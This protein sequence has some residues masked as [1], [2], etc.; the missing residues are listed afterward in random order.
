[1][2]SLE[3]ALTVLGAL[4]VSGALVSGIAHRSF[5]SLTA[6][7]VLVGVL[8]GEGGLEVL[9]FEATGAFVSALAVVALVVIL[10]RDGLEVDAEMLRTEWHLPLRKLILAMPITA[11]IVAVAVAALTDLSWTQAFLVGALLSPTDPVLSS[12]VVTNPRVPRVIRHSLNLESGLNDGLALPPVL[13][14]IAA[15]E[16]SGDDFVWW[17]FVLQDVSLGFAYGVGVGL[18]ASVLL[19]RGGALTES[20]PAH[21]K[22]LY[23]LGV[24]F[25]TYGTTTLPPHG[26][27][28][29]AVFV[30]AITLGIRRPDIRGYF[31]HRAD[32]IIEIVKLGIFV[33]FGALLTLDGLF[34]DGWAAVAVAAVTLLVARPAAVAIALAGTRVGRAAFAFMAWF[35]PKGVAT[36]TFSLLVLASGVPDAERI[37]NLGALVVLCSIVLHGLTDTPGSEWMARRAA[38][39]AQDG[40]ASAY[41]SGGVKGATQRASTSATP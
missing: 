14:L 7:F 28:F 12:S 15:L 18:L 31:E 34:G 20:I 23:A 27:G 19:P 4:L 30:C 9:R 41:S 40:G 6:A 25:V 33:V 1:M 39:D 32:D 11:A 5:L 13:A 2:T 10:F 17:Q 29:I 3:T 26:N 37:F 36:M 38:R 16:V 22:A 8:L 35:G 24:A 21:H